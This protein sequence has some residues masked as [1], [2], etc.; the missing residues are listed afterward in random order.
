MLYQA[1]GR[2]CADFVEENA[3]RFLKNKQ[4]V[5]G[6]AELRAIAEKNTGSFECFVIDSHAHNLW[7]FDSPIAVWG[8]VPRQPFIIGHHRAVAVT[9]LTA[10]QGLDAVKN[11]WVTIENSP[12]FNDRVTRQPYTVA[13]I[14]STD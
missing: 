2:L 8:K 6:D 4:T 13:K 11:A 1:L 3:Q 7:I 10:P 12:F 5:S 9:A 14:V